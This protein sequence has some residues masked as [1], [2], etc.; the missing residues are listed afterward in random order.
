MNTV[1]AARTSPT[2]SRGAATATQVTGGALV[3]AAVAL[4]RW[5][6]PPDAAPGPARREPG[7]R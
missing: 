2:S 1:L 5:A 3:V 7:A 4:I 6:E